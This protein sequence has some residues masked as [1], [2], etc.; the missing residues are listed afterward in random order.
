MKSVFFE[1]D[2]RN[3]DS[4]F[5]WIKNRDSV[6]DYKSI[7]RKYELLPKTRYLIHSTKYY[8]EWNLLIDD[9]DIYAR[10]LRL[11]LDLEYYK[12]YVV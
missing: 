10:R 4:D 1:Y 9:N 11:V 3:Y 7:F 6:R 12:E 2:V 5:E 8:L